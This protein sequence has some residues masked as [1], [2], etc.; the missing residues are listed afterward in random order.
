MGEASGGDEVGW[1]SA[2]MPMGTEQGCEASSGDEVRWQSTTMIVGT[3]GMEQGG[4]KASSAL[5]AA[6]A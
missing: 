2:A 1:Q 5:E 3:E 6:A 4:G